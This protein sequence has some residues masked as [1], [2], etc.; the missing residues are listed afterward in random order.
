MI[1]LYL[2]YAPSGR[3]LYNGWGKTR[4]LFPPARSGGTTPLLHQGLSRRL[5]AIR[6]AFGAKHAAAFDKRSKTILD[7]I[8]HCGFIKSDNLC[9]RLSWDGDLRAECEGII[10]V[11][12][13]GIAA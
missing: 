7:C 3:D 4:R 5:P 8:Q 6:S 2:P 12:E 1:K 13:E 11:R 9:E 10:Q